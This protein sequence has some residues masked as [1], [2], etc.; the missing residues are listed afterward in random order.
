MTYGEK[1]S[2]VDGTTKFA[3]WQKGSHD[4]SG[5]SSNDGGSDPPMT[6]YVTQEEFKKAVADI[7]NQFV[8]V[9]SR[10]EQTSTKADLGEMRADIAEMKA[11]VSDMKSELIKWMVGTAI[12]L[13]VAAITVM[14]FVLNN[15]V[16]KS[17][18]PTQP[19]SIVIQMP[20]TAPAPALAPP[21]TPPAK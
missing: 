6:N 17:V 19:A 5:G 2:V 21:A 11:G 8:R 7:D 3:N 15:A 10:L 4:G 18:S 13:G 16:P 14:T 20:G 1:S 12:G 9:E